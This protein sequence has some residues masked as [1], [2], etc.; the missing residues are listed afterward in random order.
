MKTLTKSLPLIA[1]A[2]ILVL[3]VLFPL[4]TGPYPHSIAT[5]VLMYMTLAV[6]WD[7]LLRSGQLSF[8]IAGF[9]GLGTYA[10]VL[11][12]V[13]L[14][15]SPGLALI[16]SAAFAFLF[17]VILGLM[18]LN[19]RAMYFAITTL[20]LG[21]IFRIVIRNWISF[22]GGPEGLVL[23]NVIFGGSSR[24][25]YWMF[26]GIALLAIVSSIVFERSRMH[27]ALTSIRN[28]ETVAKSS[29]IGIFKYLVLAFAITSA[30]QALAGGAYAQ[31][32][33]FVTPE[34]SFNA[35][36][37]L[38]PLAMALLGGIYSTWGPVIGAVLLG[39]VAEYLK[40]YIPYGHLVVYG[41]IILLVILFMPNGIVGL[42][43]KQLRKEAAR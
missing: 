14:G 40:L 1:G 41:L 37:T 24:A 15:L 8:G 13:K 16:F 4:F 23:P 30:I 34:S 9:F 17:A 21:E 29:G 6:S 35:D 26:L 42:L 18:V 7:M 20:A 39:V 28:N 19:L 43:R 5:T 27:Y 22:T 31:M 38:L 25:M 3:A 12:I 2:V 11:S 36:Y 10:S 33:G 32:Y